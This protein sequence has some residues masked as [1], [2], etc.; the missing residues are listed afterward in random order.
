[1]R[2]LFLRTYVALAIVVVAGL[3]VAGAWE[4]ARRAPP[5]NDTLQTVLEAPEEVRSTFAT[6]PQED[7]I[8]TLSVGLNAEIAVVTW[9]ELPPVTPPVK[10]QLRRG[11]PALPNPGGPLDLWVPLPARGLVVHVRPHSTLPAPVPWVA[12][13]V[14]IGLGVAVTRLLRPLDR[15]LARLAEAAHAFGQGDRSARVDPV[16]GS[17]TRDLDASFNAMADRIGE[18]LDAQRDLLLAVSHELRTPMNRVRFAAELLATQPD[19]QARERELEALQGDLD[20]LD[21]LVQELLTWGRLD[22]T[23]PSTAAGPVDVSTLTS[24]LLERERR[25]RPELA[26]R[27]EVAPGVQVLAQEALLRRALGNVIANAR[28]HATSAVQVRVHVG[29]GRVS[30]HVDDDGP[31]IPWSERD[32]VMQPFVRLD[33]ARTRDAGGAGLGLALA[34]RIAQSHGGS[35]QVGDAPLGGARVTLTLPLPR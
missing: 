22:Q 2:R 33:A 5:S 11:R 20:E 14:L 23:R 3:L 29:G 4:S 17:P 25:L 35:L 19:P 8:A 27:A 16:P 31:G 15:Q 34:N 6:L 7:A 1:M 32:R 24:D 26:M 21:E 10:A 18:L 30:V 12:A 28:R 9:D 13:A